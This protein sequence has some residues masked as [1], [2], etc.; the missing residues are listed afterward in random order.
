MRGYFKLLMMAGALT[1]TA[2][3]GEVPENIKQGLSEIGRAVIDPAA[4]AELYR[5]LHP[6]RPAADVQVTRA[7]SYGPDPR[8]LLDV[9]RPATAKG[10]A[11]VLVFV[12]GGMGDR[13]ESFPN[14]EP[15]NDN[16]MQW[17][18]GQQMVAVKVGR[19]GVL[20]GD[21]NG[22]DVGAAVRWVHD[23]I[24]DYGGDPDR[25]F[26]WG[27]SAGAMSIADYLARDQF[28]AG[29]G[30]LVAGAILM[31]GPYKLHPIAVPDDGG[32]KVRLTKDGPIV[33]PPPV[34][35]ALVAGKS[36][37]PGMIALRTP[38]MLLA[39]ERDPDLLLNSTL[40]LSD[41]LNK[42]GKAHGF[43]ILKYHNHSSEIFSVNTADTSA[44]API[45]EWINGVER[46]R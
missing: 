37:V 35:P 46:E 10:D 18:A 12:T 3:R 1:A 42:A 14:C 29:R 20:V 34:D 2:A 8:N 9:F 27:Y 6:E 44:T 16:V 19:R 25:V 24:A 11:R 4:T 13:D 22:E 7:I 43:R 26:I 15:Y 31:A 40:L 39:S 41:E 28:Q 5:S 21:E 38:F 30:T 33:S 32:L 36:V 17:A 23:H 45:L